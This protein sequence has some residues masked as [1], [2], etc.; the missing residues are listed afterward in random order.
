MEEQAVLA[1]SS[2]N[3]RPFREAEKRFTAWAAQAE[4]LFVTEFDSGRFYKDLVDLTDRMDE[5]YEMTVA[6][7][8]IQSVPF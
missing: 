4:A 8:P 7:F 5:I 6:L 3:A 2:E 1:L